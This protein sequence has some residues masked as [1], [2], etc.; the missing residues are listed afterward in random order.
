MA[1]RDYYEILGVSRDADDR[2][3]KKAFR[4]KSLKYHPDRNPGDTHAEEQF[5]LVAEAYEVLSNAEKRRLYDQFGHEGLN[6]SGFSGFRNVDDIFSHFSDFFGE[7]FGFGQRR[8]SR[9]GPARGDDIQIDLEISYEEAATGIVRDISIRQPEH[10]DSCNGTGAAPGT[11]PE[12]CPTCQGQGEVRMR[13]GF[14]LVS[15]VCPQC[16][17]EGRVI[18]KRCP[19]CHGNGQKLVDKT[20]SVD[21]PAGIDDGMRIRHRGRGGAGRRGGPPGD[22]Y[23]L[24]RLA[25]HPHLVRD[26]YDVHSEVSISYTR[27]AL[28]QTLVIPA[29]KGETQIEIPPGTQPN[30]TITIRNA[31]FPRLPQDGRGFGDHIVHVR[32]VIPHSLTSEER[33]LLE[34]LASL[35]ETTNGKAAYETS[36]KPKKKSFFQR[37]KEAV[38]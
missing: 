19:T 21:I 11:S 30:D 6:S 22:L 14:L 5:K 31:G 13:Q 10:C 33:S 17:G 38:E 16:R 35:E 7:F 29:L 32:V 23:V 15:T 9:N 1:K 27:A 34:K 37:L 4:E 25:E 26:G 8:Q 12:T 28:G 3:I 36:G 24:V 2:T 20:I 18:K